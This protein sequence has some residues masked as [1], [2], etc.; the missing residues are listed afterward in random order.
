MSHDTY[1]VGPPEAYRPYSCHSPQHL[2]LRYQVPYLKLCHLVRAEF[3]PGFSQIFS[4][5]ELD[6]LDR[7]SKG[8]YSP[9][10][11][12]APLGYAQDALDGFCARQ[13][14]VKRDFKVQVRIDKS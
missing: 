10:A 6:F 5:A 14:K 9:K 3:V 4:K 11:C 2:F 7:E 1:H 12:S 8:H 13:L